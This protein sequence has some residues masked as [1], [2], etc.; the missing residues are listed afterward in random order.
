MKRHI[1]VRTLIELAVGKGL[2]DMETDLVRSVR[3]LVDLGGYF[4]KGRFQQTFFQLPR[5]CFA[6][7][8]A[9]TIN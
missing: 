1:I 2:R 7:R 4:A 3:N 6:M 8:T 5:P 9:H